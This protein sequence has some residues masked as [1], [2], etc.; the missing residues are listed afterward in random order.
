MGDLYAQAYSDYTDYTTINGP[1]HIRNLNCW[2]P[3]RITTAHGSSVQQFD[4]PYWGKVQPFA[5]MHGAQFRPDKQHVND[6]HAS[7]HIMQILHSSASLTD[8]QKVCI[9]YWSNGP[10]S[11]QPPGHWCLIAQYIARRDAYN[12]D[13]TIKLFFILTNALLD[14]S[15]ACWDCKRAYN[16]ARPLSIIRSLFKGR[17]I[18]AW[19]GPQRG[20]RL[21]EGQNWQPYQP[22]EIVTPTSPAYCSEHSAFSATSAAILNWFT[23]SNY[24]G[25]SYTRLAGTSLIEPG[26]V[27][28][29]NITLSWKTFSSAAAEAGMSQI[30]GGVHFVKSDSDGKLLGY[31]VAAT[32]WHKAQNFING[33]RLS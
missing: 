30:Y 17:L 20:T 8:R 26:S 13:T 5:M 3:Q 6:I 16:A 23:G 9:E 10:D 14:A 29:N 24:F 19:A 32:V 12:L 4:V 1:D 18:H 21:L 7:E 11:E 27:P 2:Q 28:A 33:K 22:T 15:I 25:G 31:K